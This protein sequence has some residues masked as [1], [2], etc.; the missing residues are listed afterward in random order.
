[1]S[2]RTNVHS[3]EANVIIAFLNQKGGVGKTTLAINLAAAAHI[4][5][6]RTLLI[7]LDQQGSALD[8]YAARGDSADSKLAGLSTVKL[9]RVVA[10]HQFDQLAAGYDIVVL[11]GPARL[12]EIT[13][14]AGVA[15]DLVVIPVQ[16]GPFDLWAGSETLSSL[17]AAQG[18]RIT[19]GR[20]PLEVVWVVNRAST[21]TTLARQAPEVLAEAGEV[22]PIMI[23]QRIEFAR[24]AAVGEGVLTTEPKGAAAAEI[25][26]LYTY[27]TQKPIRQAA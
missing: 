2:T 5:G 12:G 14:A 26:A 19:I 23:H 9:D 16:P 4:Q 22:A 17:E 13:R 15:A 3:S 10:A 6:R 7:D 8:W 25:R 18:M 21:G 11:D 20:A 1:M 24:S 27:L